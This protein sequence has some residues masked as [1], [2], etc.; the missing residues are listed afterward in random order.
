MI[1]GG[2]APPG[3]LLS[4]CLRR[5]SNGDDDDDDV[6]SAVGVLLPVGQIVLASSWLTRFIKAWTT[7]CEIVRRYCPLVRPSVAM[8]SPNL[9]KTATADLI[10]YVAASV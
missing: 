7:V 2:A 5:Q 9:V 1:S 6:V 4:T 8:P 10:R 3:P